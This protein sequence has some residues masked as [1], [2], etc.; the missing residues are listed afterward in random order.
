VIEQALTQW[1]M[2][3]LEVMGQPTEVETGLTFDFRPHRP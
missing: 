1:Q 3:P 2:K